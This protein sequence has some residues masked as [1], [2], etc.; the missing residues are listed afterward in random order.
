LFLFC[1]HY[2]CPC[3]AEVDVPQS[4]MCWAIYFS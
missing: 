1:A 2:K 4:N 3:F